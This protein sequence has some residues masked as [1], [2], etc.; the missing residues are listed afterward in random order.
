MD[1]SNI[2]TFKRPNEIPT[3]EQLA[4]IFNPPTKKRRLSITS[5]IPKKPTTINEKTSTLLNSVPP[6][7]IPI[8]HPPSITSDFFTDITTDLSDKNIQNQIQGIIEK[9][10]PPIPPIQPIQSDNEELSDDEKG[11]IMIPFIYPPPPI[12]DLDK[13]PFS[14]ASFRKKLGYKR[15]ESGRLINDEDF[16]EDEDEEDEDDDDYEAFDDDDDE[17]EKEREEDTDY[18]SET[19]VSDEPPNNLSLLPKKPKSTKQSRKLYVQAPPL[20]F[21]PKHYMQYPL[22]ADK[23]ALVPE[24]VFASFIEANEEI[25][26]V[27]M[28]IAS[29]AG[30]LFDLRKEAIEEGLTI[31]IFEAMSKKWEANNRRNEEILLSGDETDDSTK[32][33][34]LDDR[35][36]YYQNIDTK[37]YEDPYKSQWPLEKQDQIYRDPKFEKI[38]RTISNVKSTSSSGKIP[39]QNLY[40]NIYSYP[41][42]VDYSFKRIDRTKVLSQTKDVANA[43]GSFKERRRKNLRSQLENLEEYEEENK[44]EI[45]KFQKYQLLERLKNLK[46]SKIKFINSKINDSELSELNKNFEI[47]RDYELV[48][49]KIFEKYELLKNSLLFYEDSNN[50]YK[51]LNSLFLN[52]LEKLKNFFEY[53]RDL[54]KELLEEKGNDGEEGDEEESSIFDITSKESSRLFN[55][56]ANDNELLDLDLNNQSEL[57]NNNKLITELLNISSDSKN[58][59]VHDFMPLISKE[60]FDI[61][62]NDLPKNL[63]PGSTLS[64]S[65]NLKNSRKHAIFANSIYD[66]MMTSGSD[67]NVSDKNSKTVNINEKPTPKRR[68]RRAANP[69]QTSTQQNNGGTASGSD[70]NGSSNITAANTINFNDRFNKDNSLETKYSEAALLAKINKQFIGPQMASTNE[71]M[72]DLELM[73]IKTKWPIK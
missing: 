54:F 25:P 40:K 21:P 32:Q 1:H 46:S 37:I 20:P 47:K 63:K 59:I 5:T 51:Q 33:Q 39:T 9:F 48:K 34:K 28:V 15:S 14:I 19:P 16:D 12:I 64:G 55:G 67:T 53:Q 18:N 66:K 60:E 56:I 23:S 22:I 62:T 49:L 70:R 3:R 17:F 58:P 42:H 11:G 57:N 45:Y 44:S 6:N 30:S 38:N 65:S 35:M 24:E 69:P 10:P 4:E 13:L 29:A 68:G 61:I 31:D 26:R 43:T 73:G 2:S 50:I 72:N 71:M 27:D 8:I 52:K 7:I 36:K 41:R